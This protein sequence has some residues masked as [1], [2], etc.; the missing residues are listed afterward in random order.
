MHDSNNQTSAPGKLILLGEYAVLE[1]APC[2]VSAVQ[3]RCTTDISSHS[4]DSIRIESSRDDVPTAEFT[5]D[6]DGE[7]HYAAD[8]S[9]EDYKR[10]RF[11]LS[12]LENVVEQTEQDY[13]GIN[14]YINTDR[15]FHPSGQKLGLGASA[16]ITVSLL[17]ALMKY[18]GTVL[19][20]EQLYSR[21]FKI[22][23]KA[24]GGLGSG[25]DIAASS[26]GGVIEYQLSAGDKS[27]GIIKQVQWP[28]NLKMMSIWAGH[29]A[30]TQNMVQQ[31]QAYRDAHPADYNAVMEPMKNISKAGCDAFGNNDAEGFTEAI[32][33]FVGQE[34]KLGEAS[35]ADIISDAHQE[36]GR[37]VQEAGGIYKP[38]GAGG[39]DIGVAFCRRTDSCNKIMNAINDSAFDLLDLPLQTERN[40][41]NAY[42]TG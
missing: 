28:D 18:S 38:S 9:S 6:D 8:F 17:E 26:M 40:I 30:S 24:Q 29:S 5:I 3:K 22:H 23:R 7:F 27:N 19:N 36:I 14:I 31:V 32:A 12:T 11:V 20:S 41:A 34:Q 25:M 35:Q 4:D 42:Q 10:L 39:G 2:L 37:L 13:T 33:D 21:A 1:E 16:A 15:F